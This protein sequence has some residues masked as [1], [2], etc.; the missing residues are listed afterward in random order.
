[1]EIF[2]V[3]ALVPLFF[4]ITFLFVVIFLSHH[5]YSE[6]APGATAGMARDQQGSSFGQ[7]SLSAKSQKIAYSF[8]A[9]LL[10][11]LCVVAMLDQRKKQK[12]QV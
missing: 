7:R 5:P 4:F 2:V 12:Q 3:V 11:G 8:L 6:H 9:L 10:T 1:M